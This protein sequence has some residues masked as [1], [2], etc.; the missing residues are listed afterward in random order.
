VDETEVKRT[1]RDPEAAPRLVAFERRD[2]IADLIRDRG[3]VRASE[4]T[5]LFGVTDETIRRDLARLA[6]Q[7]VLRRAHGG[8]VATPTRAESTFERRLHEHEEEKIAI[9]RAAAGLVR[10]GSTIIIDSGTTTVHFARALADKRDLV[11]ITNAVT[12]AIELIDSPSVMVV[13]TG[14]LVRPATLGAVGDLAVATLRELHVDQ[15]FLAM[16]SIT[17][18]GGLTYPS[19]EEVAVK[20]AMIAA[21]TEVI[22][23]ADHSKFGHNSLVRVAPLDAVSTIVTSAD[24]DPATVAAMREMG[25]EVLVADVPSAG[26]VPMAHG[27]AAG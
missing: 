4:L 18:A 7:G 22:L 16:S 26:T 3:S 10:D 23:L 25:I 13:L 27:E 5:D 8:A 11:V 12:N 24:C 20:R 15:V 1:P 19:F 17:I 6:D 9:A 21:A 2:R 14:G